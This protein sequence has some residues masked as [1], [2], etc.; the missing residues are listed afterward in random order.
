LEGFAGE[1]QLNVAIF[2]DLDI[3]DQANIFATINLAQTKVNR[4]LVYDLF[5]YGR[6]RS[7]ARTAHLL[8]RAL[9]REPDSPFQDRIKILGYADDEK[10]ETLTQALFVEQLLSHISKDFRA[11]RDAAKRAVPLEVYYG[12]DAARYH[13]RPFFLAGQDETIG[14]IVWNFFDA[15]RKRWPTSWTSTERGQ[16]LNRSTG[17]IALMRFLRDAYG[18][19]ETKPVPKVTEFETLFAQVPI[20]DG[21]FTREAFAPGSSGQAELYRQLVATTTGH[22]NL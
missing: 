19:V 1:F 5:E 12:R 17:F 8:C 13:L 22:L 16:V 4:S 21:G 2:V 20:E 15:V 11:D 6:V 9:N 18:Q 14:A 7:P 3:E 10:K